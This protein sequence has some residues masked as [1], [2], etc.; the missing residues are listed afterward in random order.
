MTNCLQ[1]RNVEAQQMKDVPP[2]DLAGLCSLPWSPHISC[3]WAPRALNPCLSDITAVSSCSRLVWG[4]PPF[5]SL[6]WPTSRLSGLSCTCLL[7]MDLWSQGCVWP[8][9]L[10]WQRQYLKKLS[11]KETT[12]YGKWEEYSLASQMH[13]QR[14]SLLIEALPCAHLQTHLKLVLCAK[15]ACTTRTNI[16]S[17]INSEGLWGC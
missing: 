11:R 2:T 4:H 17:S 5:W 7:P 1:T 12:F 13:L 6:P 3:P 15:T 8:Y 16:I 10:P 9:S 14:Y